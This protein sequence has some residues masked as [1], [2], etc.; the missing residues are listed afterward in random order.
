MRGECGYDRR[1]LCNARLFGRRDSGGHVVRAAPSL[2][3]SPNSSPL[4]DVRFGSVTDIEEPPSDVCFTPQSRHRLSALGCP[5]D[6][7]HHCWPHAIDKSAK[8]RRQK[9]ASGA[10]YHSFVKAEHVL[11]GIHE[12]RIAVFVAI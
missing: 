9:T 7:R 11:D 12:S 4:R 6:V 8:V 3:I 10:R 2:I 5:A 1:N